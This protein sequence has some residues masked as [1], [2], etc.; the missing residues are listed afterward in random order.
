MGETVTRKEKE[1]RD[2]N[3]GKD[4]RKWREKEWRGKEGKKG[5]ERGR[6]RKRGKVKGGEA[7]KRDKTKSPLV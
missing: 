5:R 6:G 2:T 7:G 1:Q 3:V 4:G